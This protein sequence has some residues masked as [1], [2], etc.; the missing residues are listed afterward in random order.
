MSK[1]LGQGWNPHYSTDPEPQQWQCQLLNSLL[2]KGTPRCCYVDSYK[3][4]LKS[5]SVSLKLSLM[6]FYPTLC[7]NVWDHQ[8]SFIH[9]CGQLCSSHDPQRLLG[10]NH[11]RRRRVQQEF[12]PSLIF[13]EAGKAERYLLLKFTSPLLISQPTSPCAYCL[14]SCLHPS[15]PLLVIPQSHPSPPS[16]PSAGSQCQPPTLESPWES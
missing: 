9:A 7:N 15:H 4:L 11:I 3:G 13:L 1:F 10:R 8:E 2:Q 16:Y 14:P 5:L 12:K 6:Y